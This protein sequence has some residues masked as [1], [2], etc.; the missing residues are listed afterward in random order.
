MKRAAYYEEAKR[1]YV[2]EGFSL[3]AIEKLLKDTVTRR[4]LFNWK[5]E[6]DWDAQRAQYIKD[7]GDTLSGLKEILRSQI[8]TTKADPNPANIYAVVK[9]LAAIEKFEKINWDKFEKKEEEKPIGITK[10]TIERIER[11]VLGL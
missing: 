7:S 4:T 2:N 8:N 6:N 1:L 11:E 10:E 5:S 3:D 9:I